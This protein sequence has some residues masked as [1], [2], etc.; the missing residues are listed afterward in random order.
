MWIFHPN[1]VLIMYDFMGLDLG[2]YFLMKWIC[3]LVC[4]DKQT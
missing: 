3:P 1:F 2:K 4:C